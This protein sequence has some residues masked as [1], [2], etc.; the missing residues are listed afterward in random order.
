MLM[1][2]D[3]ALMQ[4]LDQHHLA[5]SMSLVETYRLRAVA[6]RNRRMWLYLLLAGAV[7]AGGVALVIWHPNRLL[8]L[9]GVSQPEQPLPIEFVDVAPSKSTQPPAQTQRRA[10]V[11]S[12]A[13]GN[14]NP[15]LP[16]QAGKAPVKSAPSAV[17]APAQR[18]PAPPAS[19]RAASPSPS[20]RIPIPNRAAASVQPNPTFPAQPPAS[21]LPSV[22]PSSPPAT[23]QTPASPSAAA[24]LGTPLTQSLAIEGRGIDGQ[25]NPDRTEVEAGIDAAQD[26]LWGSYLSAL[27][28]TV[29]QNWQR[30]SVAATSRTRIQFRVDRQGQLTDLRVLQPSGDPQADQAALDAVRAAAPFAPLPQNASEEVLIVNFTFTQWLTPASP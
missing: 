16:I 17:P 15:K 22:Q 6:K 11:N 3:V 14:R 27:N 20:R 26:N 21:P 19:P 23:S 10:Q 28:R 29:D 8:E 18:T 30:V 4:T 13:G 24:Q 25:L 1:S 5:P 12:T 7:H 9:V 2:I